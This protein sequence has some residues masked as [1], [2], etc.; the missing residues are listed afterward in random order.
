RRL[1]VTSR[2][3]VMSFSVADGS[4]EW[5]SASWS[6]MFADRRTLASPRHWRFLVR[7]VRF[8]AQAR[9]DLSA[10]AVLAARSLDEY[11]ALRRIPRDIRDHFV[12]PLAAALWSLAPERCGDF[13]ALTYL[14]FL[15][16]HGML[17]P[18]R[19]L[20]W[21]TIAGG[22]RRY[23]DALLADLQRRSFALELATPVRGIVRSGGVAIVTDAGSRRFDRVVVAT[24]ADTALRLLAEPTRA[25]RAA[26]GAIRYSSNRTVLHTDR[27]FLPRH[28]AAHAA[29][30]YV[31]DP[32]TARVAVTY[33]MTRLQGLPDRPYLVTLNPRR[34][35]RGILHEVE[36]AHPQFDRAALAAREQL[37]GMAGTLGTYYAGAHFGFGFHE[38]G[39]RSGSEAAQR[40]VADLAIRRQA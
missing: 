35:P 1:G 24:H 32:D 27:A 36:F 19:P 29:W 16:Q 40:L 25:E 11:L 14:A 15:E 34:E 13:P 4:H 20:A 38:D 28:P 22:S 18:T 30:N 37:E 8:L 7:V 3:T 10:P 2:P 17:S 33:S 23:V 31:A 39:L 26:L 12:I 6:A 5:G 21:H 9:R